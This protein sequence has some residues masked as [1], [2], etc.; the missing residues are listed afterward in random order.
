M[1]LLRILHIDPLGCYIKR[2]LSDGQPLFF[3]EGEKRRKGEEEKRR[4]GEWGEWEKL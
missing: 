1:S 3:I 2:R 4:L